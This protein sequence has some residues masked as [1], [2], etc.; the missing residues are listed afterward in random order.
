[1]Y[2][3]IN[4][5]NNDELQYLYPTTVLIAGH[6]INLVHYQTVFPTIDSIFTLSSTS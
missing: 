4:P 6:S 5:Q 2:I 1:M 3:L